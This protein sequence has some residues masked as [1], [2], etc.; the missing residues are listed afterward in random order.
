M[1]DSV[2]ALDLLLTKKHVFY[3]REFVPRKNIHEGQKD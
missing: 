2:S 3:L 1:R